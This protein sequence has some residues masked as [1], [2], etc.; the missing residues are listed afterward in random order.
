MN[1]A[2]GVDRAPA[3]APVAVR[4]QGSFEHGPQVLFRDLHLSLP[5]E[6]WTCL[7]GVSGV[8][9][10]TVLRLIAGLPTGGRF[11]GSIEAG[12]G[13]TVADRIAYMAQ[14]DLLAPWL[15]VR[16]N[17]AL[18]HRLRG[19][20]VSAGK[21]DALLE[22]VGLL[23][24]AGKR[25]AE[26]SGG[27]RQ[28][29]ALARTLLQDTA[30]VLLDEPFS[31]LDA[32]T[33]ADMQE[34]AFVLLAGKSVLLVTHDPAEASRLGQQILVMTE[35]GMTQVPVPA[36]APIRPVD[37]LQVLQHQALLLQWLRHPGQTMPVAS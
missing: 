5:S 4:L 9:K 10:S 35:A 36:V 19:E 28:R 6:G 18:G 8:G 3:E 34:L 29:A 33:R 37:D 16:E 11:T 22:R 25:P 13:G 30:I 17:L 27:M 26:L 1:S 21:V 32:R 24:H 2:E 15:S 31:A 20:T 12:D 14:A 7:L 23:A